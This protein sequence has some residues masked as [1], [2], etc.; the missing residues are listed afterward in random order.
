M[1][2]AHAASSPTVELAVL[3]INGAAIRTQPG[4]AAAALDWPGQSS[5]VTVELFPS[6]AGRNSTKQFSDGRWAIVAF[7]RAGR[8]RVSGNVADVTQQVG[9]RTITYKMEFDSTTVPFLMPELADF[10]CPTSLE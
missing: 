6:E 8:A 10:A 5:G 1:S 3:Q 4:G 7:M 2:V 9:G